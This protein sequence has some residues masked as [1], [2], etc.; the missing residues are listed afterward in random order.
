M[1][2]GIESTHLR[3]LPQSRRSRW[4]AYLGKQG[5]KEYVKIKI[6]HRAYYFKARDNSPH[7]VCVPNDHVLDALIEGAG[8][9]DRAPEGV[10]LVAVSTF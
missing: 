8:E 5:K 7:V 6:D 9:E 3:R 1:R 10:V 4:R 2:M